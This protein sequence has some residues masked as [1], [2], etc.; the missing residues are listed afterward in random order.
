MSFKSFFKAH[1]T[2]NEFKDK[3]SLLNEGK[4]WTKF[5]EDATTILEVESE[6][7]GVVKKSKYRVCK[8]EEDDSGLAYVLEK[9]GRRYGL[10]RATE[11]KF[12]VIRFAKGKKHMI[13]P[14]GI[15]R[16]IDGKLVFERFN[17][18]G[19]K[20]LGGG[21]ELIQLAKNRYKKDDDTFHPPAMPSD[22]EKALAKQPPQA[23]G[24]VSSP[25][26]T[27]YGLEETDSNETIVAGINRY[28][29][30]VLKFDARKIKNW[31]ALNSE[32]AGTFWE[33]TVK[34]WLEQAGEK[35]LG[36]A[37]VSQSQIAS[38]AKRIS[39]YLI[40][41]KLPNSVTHVRKQIDK[42]PHEFGNYG[43]EILDMVNSLQKAAGRGEMTERRTNVEPCKSFPNGEKTYDKNTDEW[44]KGVYT[45]AK[46]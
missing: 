33:E 29:T 1:L 40:A 12:H 41:N 15:F 7:D 27:I 45:D 11:G 13:K 26:E 24:A 31:W 37:V 32:D 17:L 8:M 36:E 18:A 2:E 20:Q 6:K 5:K 16:E 38:V 23:P 28:L 35:P 39:N 19:A 10:F 43:V 46:A 25:D 42:L 21:P 34:P 30:E 44:N 9:R 3:F 4:W 14:K 22:L